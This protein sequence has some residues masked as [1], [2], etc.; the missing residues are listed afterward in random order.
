M[1]RRAP[2]RHP[3]PFLGCTLPVPGLSSHLETPGP[4]KSPKKRT[5]SPGAAGR[6]GLLAPGRDGMEPGPRAGGRWEAASSCHRPSRGPSLSRVQIT[7][8]GAFLTSPQVG[9][10]RG[11]AVPEPLRGDGSWREETRGALAMADRR[12]A[13]GPPGTREGAGLPGSRPAPAPPLTSGG[14]PHEVTASGVTR[15]RSPPTPLGVGAQCGRPGGEK[16]TPSAWRQPMEG[17]RGAGRREAMPMVRAPLCHSGPSGQKAG[18]SPSASGAPGPAFAPLSAGGGC[19]AGPPA[20]P[21]GGRGSGGNG[22]AC[23][24]LQGEKRRGQQ[25][26]SAGREP[27]TKQN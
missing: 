13:A 6:L 27:R 23:T 9:D 2:G 26:C 12:A 19:G 1:D 22:A 20:P 18:G 15:G 16:R 24:S 25:A 7:S 17:R 3:S 8:S 10:V 4:V 5:R 14:E 21:P 11:P